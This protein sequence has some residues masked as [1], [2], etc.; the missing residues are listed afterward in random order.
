[1]F[2]SR[3]P[4]SSAAG[5]ASFSYRRLVSSRPG[6][7]I[8]WHFLAAPAVMAMRNPKVLALGVYLKYSA[9]GN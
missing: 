7:G 3:V 5:D 8:P 9:A 6:G 2:A 1:M 4:A